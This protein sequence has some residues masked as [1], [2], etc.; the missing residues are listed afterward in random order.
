[1][2]YPISELEQGHCAAEEAKPRDQATVQRALQHSK[3]EPDEGRQEP[4]DHRDVSNEER[5]E[6]FAGNATGETEESHALDG[7]AA[8]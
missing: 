2:L 5:D 3:P 7:R 8:G 6:Q 4:D 1:M